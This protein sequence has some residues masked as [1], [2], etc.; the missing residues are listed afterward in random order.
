VDAS[1]GVNS[2]LETK[3][4]IVR[5]LLPTDAG[6]LLEALGDPDTMRYFPHPFSYDEVLG[7][8]DRARRS[9]AQWGFGL[10]ALILKDSG[11]LIGDCGLTQ[12]KVEG[13]QLV[14]IGYHLK[15]AHWHRGLAT[16]AARACTRYA[17]ESLDV[18]FIIA[19]VRPENVPSAAVVK[20]LGMRVWKSV[21]YK[22]LPHLVYRV[23]RQDFPALEST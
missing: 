4:L 7:W 11:E 20:R 16:E 5:K 10:W 8:I 17:F 22:G 6:D 14:E 9:Y 2:V 12:Q 3:R 18:D 15:K 19:L 23:D 13:E 1:L 21:H